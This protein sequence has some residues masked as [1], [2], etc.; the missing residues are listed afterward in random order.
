ME[1]SLNFTNF[2]D[3]MNQQQFEKQ[4]HIDN[5]RP[6]KVMCMNVYQNF[7]GIERFFLLVLHSGPC[8]KSWYIKNVETVYSKF[9]AI[10]FIINH[11]EWKPCFVSGFVSSNPLYIKWL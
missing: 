11:M 3:E 1:D 9:T 4:K 5:K 8:V 10:V 7:A 2:Q 6:I